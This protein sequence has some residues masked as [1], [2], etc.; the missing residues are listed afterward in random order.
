MLQF[1]KKILIRLGIK[2]HNQLKIPRT[3]VNITHPARKSDM[4]YDV[5]SED[6]TLERWPDEDGL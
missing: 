1:I 3:T 2:Q 4:Y 6:Y 5:R